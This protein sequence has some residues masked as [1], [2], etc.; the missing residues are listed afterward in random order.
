MRIEERK[1]YICSDGTIFD[2]ED[3]AQFH[4][5]ESMG[6]QEEV[7]FYNEKGKSLL[8][9]FSNIDS[10]WYINIKTEK[11]VEM[12]NLFMDEILS[13]DYH[14]DTVGLYRYDNNTYSWTSP[15]EEIKNLKASWQ[16]PVEW[17]KILT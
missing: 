11:G 8:N 9:P 1:V 14:F 16:I 3:D 7:I 4:E 17:N 6:G 2:F 12:A 13:E 15:E 5:W 10:V